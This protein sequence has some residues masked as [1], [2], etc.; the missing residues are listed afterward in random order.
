MTES[1]NIE[2]LVGKKIFFLHPSVLIQK[3]IIEEL[4][5]EE[6]EVYS[7]KDEVKLQQLLRKYPN[8][9]VF[10]NISDGM[11]ESAW[12]HWIQ[13][14]MKDSKT[15]R[16]GIGII[17]YGEDANL[18]QK[19]IGRLKLRC[20][21][22]II[23]TDLS[24]VINQLTNILGDMNAKDR[25][26]YIRVLPDK[27]TNIT[28]NLPMNGTFINGV[29]REISTAGFSCTFEDEPD[30]IRNTHYTGIQICLQTESFQIQGMYFGSRK[31]GTKIV[32]VFLVDQDTAPD[33]QAKIREFIRLHLKSRMDSELGAAATPSAA[34]T[35]SA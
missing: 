10:A 17:A 25:R 23:K 21:Y 34:L 20:G 32:Y 8:S 3:K 30:L 18:R 29:I 2:S 19:Y 16:V 1:D 13:S 33:A 35:T 14:I 4:A 22:T 28:L 24:A 26:R 7:V 27:D 6:F 11:K 9:I 15:A 12:E 5:Q 31:Q